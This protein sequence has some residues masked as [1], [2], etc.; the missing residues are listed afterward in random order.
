MIKYHML[1][2]KKNLKYV[3]LKTRKKIRSFQI[4][5]TYNNKI[6]KIFCNIYFLKGPESCYRPS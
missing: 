2:R 1:S 5:Y 4:I 3:S 6:K